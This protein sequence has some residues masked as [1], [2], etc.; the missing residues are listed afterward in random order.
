MNDSNTRLLAIVVLV[1][2]AIGA[3]WYFWDELAP[4]DAVPQLPAPA[5]P[6]ADT[7]ATPRHPVE[8]LSISAASDIELVPLPRLDES[9][10]Y[11]LLALAELLGP[12]VER[13]LVNE[14]LIDKFVATIDNLPRSHVAEK[15]RP[16]GQLSGAFLVNE[17]DANDT[18]IQHPDNFRRYD[19]LIALIANVNLDEAVALYR[20]FYPLMQESYERLGYPD[21][22]FND[23]V[24]DVIDH[25]LATPTPVEPIPL[26]Q[27]HVLFEYADPELEA[28]SSGQKLLLRMGNEH[29]A[30]V[31]RVLSS[32]RMRLTM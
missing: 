11:F 22:Y 8:P 24:V 31:K 19:V 13:L 32:I 26:V 17:A 30:T 1:A 21:A 14:A 27:P 29:A 12:G 3:G 7:P 28:L 23:R 15:I 9:D 5:E 10:E 20:R 18:Y 6:E 16:V 4:P 2:A 25:L